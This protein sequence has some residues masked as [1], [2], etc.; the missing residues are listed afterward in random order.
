MRN[1]LRG[2]NVFLLNEVGCFYFLSPWNHWNDHVLDWW[3]HKDDANVLFV[4]YED[5]KKVCCSLKKPLN[6]T[7]DQHVSYPH[8]LIQWTGGENRLTLS[9]SSCQSP[10]WRG[11]QRLFFPTNK[12]QPIKFYP[13][14]LDSSS[15]KF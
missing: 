4:K 1:S 13:I 5:L 14:N 10:E 15:W 2:T 6:S 12:R 11:V 3:K 9:V 8:Y 7:T